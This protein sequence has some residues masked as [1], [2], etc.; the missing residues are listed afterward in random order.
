M[1]VRIIIFPAFAAL[2]ILL[3][4]CASSSQ[5][6]P[7]FIVSKIAIA[8]TKPAVETPKPS[9]EIKTPAKAP[10]KKT[11]Q[12]QHVPKQQAAPEKTKELSPDKAQL[13]K[14]LPDTE[15]QPNRFLSENSFVTKWNILGPFTFADADAKEINDIIHKEFLED[16]KDLDG[17]QN[18]PQ[19]TRWNLYN[20]KEYKNIG[21]VN[22]GKLYPADRKNSAVYAVSFLQSPED[23]SNLIL[24]TG[25]KDF[26]K[27]WINGKLVHTYNKA[28]REGVWDQDIV[29][30]IKLQNG[31]NHILVKSAK[32]SNGDWNFFFRLATEDDIPISVYK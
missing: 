16:E 32:I 12:P 30:G 21:E 13:N 20:A 3:S 10:D 9:T 19:G 14:I 5:R 22:I 4:G 8:E 28:P 29:K 26:I 17:H 31:I 25:S 23:L 2:C 15:K 7:S 1:T 24:Y 6:A 27:I 11:T 18:A